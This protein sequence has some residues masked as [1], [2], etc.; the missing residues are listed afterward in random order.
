[1]PAT[2]GARFAT[3]WSPPRRGAAC[4]SRWK[5]RPASAP[6]SPMAWGKD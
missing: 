3:G 1:L 2:S 4:Q 6:A 5:K